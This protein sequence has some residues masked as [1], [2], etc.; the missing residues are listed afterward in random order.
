MKQLN[1]LLWISTAIL[2]GAA[3][4]KLTGADDF[5]FE[6]A[7][8]GG[9]AAMSGG[10]GT[11][12]R[13][14]MS[15][16][17]GTGGQKVCDECT[18]TAAPG[19]GSCRSGTCSG[20]GHA[21]DVSAPD[22]HGQPE[23]KW[24]DGTSPDP[25]AIAD[26]T[27]D[28]DGSNLCNSTCQKCSA[29]SCV[30]QT[31]A[32][33]LFGQCAKLSCSTKLCSGSNAACGVLSEGDHDVPACQRCDGTLP[34][35]VDIT[36]GAQDT[37]G[38][39]VCNTT[40]KKCFQGNCVAETG[41]NKGYGCTAKCSGCSNGTC[42]NLPVGQQDT[43]G[44]DTCSGSNA[45]DLKGQ[46]VDIHLV[47]RNHVMSDCTNA[48]GNLVATDVEA[49]QCQ[50]EGA[51]CPTGW[52]QY[53]NYTTTRPCLVNNP[54]GS[55]FS[56]EHSFS[57]TE[58]EAATVCVYSIDGTGGAGCNVTECPG[59]CNCRMTAG[60]W[61]TNLDGTHALCKSYGCTAS[62]TEIGCY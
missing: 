47:N 46:C 48:K 36:D 39:Y 18:P 58:P 10:A 42:T 38:S 43:F 12:G 25:V 8:E 20:A 59:G 53:K 30:N 54:L 5:V 19:P 26:N 27:Q 44:H 1:A 14:G 21:C 23:C 4:A 9:S 24:C 41:Y 15:G 11:S 52:T 2:A 29:G 35:P 31:A 50:F 40:C 37:E 16:S 28:Q 3:C 33:D 45:C 60:C 6:S 7:G 61:A 51:T 17:A 22:E 34:S 55:C 57:N 49:L 56:A 62:V 32:E 13:A